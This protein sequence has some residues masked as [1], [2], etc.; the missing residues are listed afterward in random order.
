VPATNRPRVEWLIIVAAVLVAIAADLVHDGPGAGGVFVYIL[1]ALPGLITYLVWRSHLASALVSL[2]PMYF[3]IAIFT[4]GR[5]SYRPELPLDRAI[6][7]EPSWM[8]V[9]GSLYVFV[10]VLPLLVVRDRAL[11]RRAMQAYLLVML[12]S[13]AVFLVYPTSIARIEPRIGDGFGAWT[14]AA[15]YSM[16]PPVNCFPSLHVAYAF[17]SAF[18]CLRVHRGLGIAAV[19]WAALI[20]ISTLFTK[21]HYVADVFA[22]FAVAC[23]SYAVFLRGAMVAERDRLR[24]PRRG[25]TALGVLVLMIAGFAVAYYF[26]S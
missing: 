25:L 8:L 6:P 4:R 20:G 24:A 13:Y 23:L 1:A 19:A 26:Q 11:I 9:Y 21:Q 5:P 18:A 3:V 2:A 15:L 7:L 16:D 10:I 17:V 14:L 22:G 12:L